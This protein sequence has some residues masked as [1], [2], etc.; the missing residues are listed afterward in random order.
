[1]LLFLSSPLSRLV[2]LVP[3]RILPLHR[4]HLTWPHTLMKTNQQSI[5]ARDLARNGLCSG[6][7]P[8]SLTTK[9]KLF[10]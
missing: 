9:V 7:C 3:V 1:M 5:L 6:L 10:L 4:F 2:F 8:D